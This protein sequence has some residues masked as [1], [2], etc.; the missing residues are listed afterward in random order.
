MP[1]TIIA[2]IGTSHN[3]SIAKAKE[4]IDAARDAGSDAVKFQWVYAHEIL[5][6]KTGF[7]ELPT[8]RI[9]L[10]ERFKELEAGA[11]FYAECGA[12]AHAKG[13]QFFCSPFGLT[14]FAELAALTPDA[15]KIASPELNHFPLLRA[16][17]RSPFPVIL[18]SGVSQLC[19]I[20][21]A[22]ALFS[23]KAE[24]TQRITLLHCVTSYPAPES[25]YNVSLVSSLQKIFGVKTGTS[26]HSLDA[27]LVPALTVFAGGTMLEKH[28]TLSQDTDGLDDPVA[29]TPK[30][31]A[32]MCE[33]VRKAEAA[34]R[35][36][37]GVD[38]NGFC[39]ALDFLE[40]DY[41]PAIIAA[42]WGSGVKTLAPAEKENYGRTNR[43]LHY[44]RSLKKGARVTADDFAILR[45]E[46]VLSAGLSPDYEALVTGAVLVRAVEDGEGVQ[47]E[48]F[49]NM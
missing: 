23:D 43:S 9:P 17:S 20:E 1:V 2:E 42:A 3:G 13:L 36:G 47:L 24:N 16:A 18:S 7:V 48:D 11:D 6:P 29:L 22:L 30:R 34:Y 44:M 25:Q 27:V 38:D 32:H 14:S 26:D 40:K 5:H 31:F 45:T 46:K 15:V 41:S 10:Y 49:I 19:D 12:Y 33:Q 37:G 39:A 28:I 21:K 8:G 35:D 4:L